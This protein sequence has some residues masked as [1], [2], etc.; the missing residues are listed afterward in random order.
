MDAA[1]IVVTRRGADRARGGH[2]WIYRSDV[3]ST[4]GAAGGAIVGVKDERG[5]MVGRALYSD[6]SEIALRLLILRDE[7]INREWWRARL[8]EA[9]AR[10]EAF[11]RGADAFRLVYAEGDALPSLIVD[12]YSDVLVLQTLSQ[13]T[14]AIKDLLVELLVEELHPRAIVERNDVRV[15]RLEGLELR[16][17]VLYGDAPAEL[18]V[19][20]H[21]VRFTVAPLA[22]QKTGAFLDQRENHLAA[23][24]Y[25]RGRALDCFTFNGG[26]ALAVA[27]GCESVVGLDISGEA[28]ATARRNAELNGLTNVEFREANVFDALRE[29][30]DAGERFDTVILDPPAFA[31][32]RASVAA[33]ARGYKEIN[34]RAIKMLEPNGVLVTCTCSYH[35]SETT[36]LET[37]ASAAADAR[38]RLQI[39]E[40]R[41]QARDHP[42]L[43]TVPE[44]LYLKCLIARAID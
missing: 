38:R 1:T 18:E 21:G 29:M 6:R 31:K 2:L 3:S 5:R 12:R 34:L 42:V 28:L 20:Q 10:R 30:Q 27:Q 23:R 8:L 24:E 44:T 15:R 9:F 37:V 33:A 4:G 32:N 41:I 25:A 35:M 26:F 11:A 13:G 43:A 16:A 22:G 40:K 19:V 14:E 39:V 7:E 17:G 36:F